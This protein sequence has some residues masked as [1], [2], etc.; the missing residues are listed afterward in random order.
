VE[1]GNFQFLNAEKNAK[2][3][4]NRF[5]LITGGAAGRML[6]TMKQL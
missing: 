5:T 6:L 4:G 2:P 1:C 3:V